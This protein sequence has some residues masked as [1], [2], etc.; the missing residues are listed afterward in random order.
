MC[1]ESSVRVTFRCKNFHD[2]TNSIIKIPEVEVQLQE[3]QVMLHQCIYII[4]YIYIYQCIYIPVCT[5]VEKWL[6]I[7]TF[8]PNIR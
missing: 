4:I 7:A 6:H 3:G 8:S 2:M 5:G 1:E